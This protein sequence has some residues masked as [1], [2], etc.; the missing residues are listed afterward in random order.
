MLE[1][2][3]VAEPVALDLDVHV[4]GRVLRRARAKAVEPQRIVVG[5][6]FSAGIQLAEDQ[7]PVEAFLLGVVIH[8]HTAAEVLHLDGAVLVPRDDDMV[9]VAR[10]RFVDGIRQDLEHGVLAP[11]QPVGAEHDPRALAH[12]V[13]ALERRDAGIIVDR[14]FCCHLVAS[15]FFWYFFP[16][17]RKTN[18]IIYCNRFLP[19]LSR[20]DLVNIGLAKCGGTC[21]T[22]AVHRSGA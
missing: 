16:R 19:H 20:P 3:R 15:S 4:L 12:A 14:L 1:M 2:Q 17:V 6:V 10:T 5:I 11:L 18:A 13:G 8:R 9:A 22:V 7:L 21:Y